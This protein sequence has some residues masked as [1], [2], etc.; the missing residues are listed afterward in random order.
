MKIT[1]V[2]QPIAFHSVK[3]NGF[4]SF[5]IEVLA[6]GVFKDKVFSPDQLAQRYDWTFIDRKTIAS[7]YAD[8]IGLLKKSEVVVF[9]NV[10]PYTIV[11]E[12]VNEWFEYVL[13]IA[14]ALPGRVVIEVNEMACKQVIEKISSMIKGKGIGLALDDYGCGLTDKCYL[15]M[16][17]WDYIKIEAD[18]WKKLP[19]HEK[20][21]LFMCGAE[22]I[23]ERVENVDEINTLISEG[24]TLMQGYAFG[25]PTNPKIHTSP[26]GENIV[27]LKP[28]SINPYQY[29]DDEGD[30]IFNHATA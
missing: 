6:R 21:H 30:E 7:F 1:G 15:T 9:I 11:S 24:V 8:F 2:Y 13:L 19:A 20:D 18:Y 28:C 5:G 22:I 23:I 4:E 25:R 26:A 14:E 29:S 12:R 10:S 16:A 27:R 3:K 17:R